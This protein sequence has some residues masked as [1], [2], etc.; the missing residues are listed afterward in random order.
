MKTRVQHDPAE[1]ASDAPTKIQIE[2][3]EDYALA[4]RRIEALNRSQRSQNEGAELEAL[5]QAVRSWD[6]RHVAG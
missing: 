3:P 1:R 2:T 4:L 6:S 5:N